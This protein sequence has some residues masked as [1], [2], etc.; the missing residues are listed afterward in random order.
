MGFMMWCRRL[1]QNVHRF[2]VRSQVWIIVCTH[3]PGLSK[4]RSDEMYRAETVGTAV[5]T[6]AMHSSPGHLDPKPGKA[7]IRP[8]P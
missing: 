2:Y 5:T 1:L 4:V 7:V 3:L 6:F 8:V